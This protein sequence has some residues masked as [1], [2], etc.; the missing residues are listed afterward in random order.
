M[1]SST[2]WSKSERLGKIIVALKL[3]RLRHL[4]MRFICRSFADASDTLSLRRT[5]LHLHHDHYQRLIMVYPHDTTS[6]EGD[7]SVVQ[8]YSSQ[9]VAHV[10]R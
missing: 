1:G 4:P 7:V 3:L 5:P 8:E 10:K 2:G 9:R 6:S